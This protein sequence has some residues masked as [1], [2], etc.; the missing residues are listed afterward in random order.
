[1]EYSDRSTS[2]APAFR[3]RAF[4]LIS[5][6][7]LLPRLILICA[8]VLL[9][10]FTDAFGQARPA[11]AASTEQAG[12]GALPFVER[13]A[14]DAPDDYRLVGSREA[15]PFAATSFDD[16]GWAL[17]NLLP[18]VDGTILSVLKQ[19]NFIYAGGRFAQAGGTEARSITRFNL[20]SR[21]WESLGLECTA[22]CEITTLL[23]DGGFLYVGG[24]LYIEQ[25]EDEDGEPLPPLLYNIARYDLQNKTWDYLGTTG[26]GN[27]IRALYVHEDMLYAGG[28]FS[29]INNVSARNIARYELSSQTWAGLGSGISAEVYAFHFTGSIG[30][31]PLLLIGSGLEGTIGN[32]EITGLNTFRPDASPGEVANDQAWGSLGDI[33]LESFADEG[34]TG[35]ISAIEETETHIF[36]S[37][38]FDVLNNQQVFSL[39]S[40]APET[41][42][43]RGFRDGNF[44]IIEDMAVHETQVYV[45][46]PDMIDTAREDAAMLRINPVLE[47]PDWE[48]LERGFDA[49]VSAV[50]SGDGLLYVAGGFKRASSHTNLGGIA[51]YEPDGGYWFPVGTFWGDEEAIVSGGDIHSSVYHQDAIIAGG[52][53]SNAGG[54][55]VNRIAAYRMETQA[56][57]AFGGGFADGQVFTLASDGTRLFAGGSFTRLADN[58]EAGGIAVYDTLSQSWQPFTG[59]VLDDDDQPG[60]I[61]ELLIHENQLFAGG[62]FTSA[63][64]TEASHIARYDFEAESWLALG[65][66]TEGAVRSLLMVDSTLYVGGQFSSAG[67][68][69]DTA[70]LAGYRL[71]PDTRGW[72][73][74]EAGIP[75][76][77]SETGVYAM[78]ALQ[79]SRLFVAGSFAG[80]AA[81]TST[82]N[83][84]AYNLRYESEDENMQPW[85]EL[86]GTPDGPVFSL[87]L[88]GDNLFAGGNFSRA[89]NALNANN[90]VRYNWAENKWLNLDEGVNAPVY[91]ITPY[92]DDIYLG[93]GF[94]SPAS[95]FIRWK[96]VSGFAGGDGSAERP[97]LVNSTQALARVGYFFDAHFLQS[98]DLFYPDQNNL[99]HSRRISTAAPLA[100]AELP[101][102]GVFDG[103]DKL[104]LNWTSISS[105]ESPK[106]F[107]TA[108]EGAVLRGVHIHKMHLRSSSADNVG[109]LVGRA[110][111]TRIEEAS[112]TGHVHGRDKVGGLIGELSGNSS[113]ARSYYS[114]NIGSS[115]QNSIDG[116]VRGRTSIGGFAGLVTGD[117]RIE[118]SFAFGKVS[119]SDDSKPAG[120]FAGTT[121][122]NAE[123]ERSYAS[124]EINPDA[125]GR[126]FIGQN[127]SPATSISFTYWNEGL[128]PSN[129]DFA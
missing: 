105:N 86:P 110:H 126:G 107:F 8:L 56:W 34:Y 58:T 119:S 73:S 48:L 45:I 106:G 5:F 53:F 9:F 97:Y 99:A 70:Y 76:G 125:N 20:D 2:A 11:S 24:A 59:G 19:E 71:P 10:A 51:G 16:G 50:I 88:Y 7:A 91:A 96:G 80:T 102:R 122:N 17:K 12:P 37:G 75:P 44:D 95:G 87:R 64:G 109:G 123:I 42:D 40:Y 100:S 65:A 129:D 22:D 35:Y 90:I 60:T 115:Y 47:L 68:L 32:Q 83:M 72:F 94:S 54:N 103:N 26:G 57:E 101:F 63:G 49:S 36:I 74:L 128:I 81:E 29:S 52:D 98:E 21:K 25:G 120:G 69:D 15:P 114:Q 14:S 28:Q 116:E 112:V 39:A 113:V 127:E 84:A 118:N 13:A 31:S 104:I 79:N 43:W 67:E 93:G 46:T 92:A 18:G 30:E 23:L 55:E 121:D 85:F 3:R 38:F 78:A 124:V 66:G 1:M 89:G 117:S 108:T 6:A 62:Q 111:N 27:S 33:R 41:Q 61:Y 77:G 82:P 4:C